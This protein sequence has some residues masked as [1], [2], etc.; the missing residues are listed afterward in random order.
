MPDPI[1]FKINFHH[2]YVIVRVSTIF[3]GLLEKAMVGRQHL[4]SIAFN[5]KE[6]YI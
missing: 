4:S 2:L 6:V 3:I 1:L 5:V